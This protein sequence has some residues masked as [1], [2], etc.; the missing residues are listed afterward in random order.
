MFRLHLRS[1]RIRQL[2]SLSLLLSNK[3]KY[4]DL[5]LE[6]A[7]HPKEPLEALLMSESDL[8]QLKKTTKTRFEGN[9]KLD[10]M[11]AEEKIAKVF[12]GR[13]K[14]ETR[15][16]SSRMNIGQ[17]RM[18]AGVSVPEKPIEPDN[19]CMSGCINC[20]WEM[21]NDD[22]KDWNA[23]RKEAALKLVEKGGVW[24]ADFHPP[25]QF[26]PSQN[27]PGQIA[28]KAK[29]SRKELE[30]ESW[31]NVP[32]LIKVFAEMEKKMKERKKARQ[33]TT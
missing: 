19:C 29:T 21:Y 4:Y 5:I 10:G 33:M 26:L 9:Y 6:T 3:Y 15:Q 31:G 28:E 23:K 17:P 11:T 20:V 22:I 2:S 32:V 27:L 18:I 13:I 8:K 16:S 12:G 14:G 24:P 7:T 30:K 1:T 25:V